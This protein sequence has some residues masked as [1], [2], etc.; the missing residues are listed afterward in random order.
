[1]I[2]DG[3]HGTP[4]P[5][6]ASEHGGPLTDAQVKVLAEGIKSHWKPAAPLDEIAARLCC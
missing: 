1:M 2:R 3:R 6:F 4:M 5:A